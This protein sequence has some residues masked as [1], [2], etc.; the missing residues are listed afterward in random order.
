MRGKCCEPERKDHAAARGK[1]GGTDQNDSETVEQRQ[2]RLGAGAEQER[3]RFDAN[4]RSFRPLKTPQPGG[5]CLITI[6]WSTR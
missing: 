5:C 4:Q 1:A 2:H 6:Y 3:G